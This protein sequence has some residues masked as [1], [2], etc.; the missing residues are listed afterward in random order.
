VA[1]AMSGG[2]RGGL[3]HAS[4]IGSSARKSRSRLGPHCT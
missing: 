1:I 2:R 4:P 3:F